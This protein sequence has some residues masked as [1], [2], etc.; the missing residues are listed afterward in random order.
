MSVDY[1][2][3][4]IE[5]ANQGVATHDSA[6]EIVQE[7]L[8]SARLTLNAV[9]PVARVTVHTTAWGRWGV[10]IPKARLDEFVRLLWENP[11]TLQVNVDGEPVYKPT[12]PTPPTERTVADVEKEFAAFKKKVVEV[13]VRTRREEDWCFT[14]FE[15]AMKELGLEFPK[16]NAQIVLEVEVPHDV[17]PDDL[18]SVQNWVKYASNRIDLGESVTSTEEV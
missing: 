13:A 2:G 11:R 6:R 4:S 3:F 5:H 7:A 1:N 12:D 17:D 9:G 10:D 14:G 16:K 15:A 8:R 18:K